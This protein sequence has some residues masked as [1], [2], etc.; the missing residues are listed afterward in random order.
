MDAI[1]HHC[2]TMVETTTF[3]GIYRGIESFQGFLGGAN[4]FHNHRQPW[5]E[6]IA[7]VWHLQGPD[8]AGEGL[9][10]PE[11]GCKAF[12]GGTS[13]PTRQVINGKGGAPNKGV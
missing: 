11:G 2:G 4:G 12:V 7:T 3:V 10:E 1:L 9:S 13:I 5:S 6:A 8:P